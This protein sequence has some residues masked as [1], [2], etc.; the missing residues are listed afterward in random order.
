MYLGGIDFEIINDDIIIYEDDYSKLNMINHLCIRYDDNGKQYLNTFLKKY[1]Q[2]L[3][4]LKEIDCIHSGVVL[5]YIPK[6]V[7]SVRA[8]QIEPDDLWQIENLYLWNNE[9]NTIFTIENIDLSKIKFLRIWNNFIT[10]FSQL[11]NLETFHLMCRIWEREYKDINI[12]SNVLTTHYSYTGVYDLPNS[13]KKLRYYVKKETD[14][15][16][17]RNL[18]EL[19]LVFITQ[20][21]IKLSNE[22]IH[23]LRIEFYIHGIDAVDLDFPNLNSLNVAIISEVS[24]ND[25]FTNNTMKLIHNLLNPNCKKLMFINLNCDFDLDVNNIEDL[26]I[27][28]RKSINYNHKIISESIKSIEIENA[29]IE[30]DLPNLN[31]FKTI[32]NVTHCKINNMGDMRKINEFKMY[33]QTRVDIRLINIHINNLIIFNDLPHLLHNIT[34]PMNYETLELT[35]YYDSLLIHH[36]LLSLNIYY[37][38]IHKD[39]FKSNSFDKIFRPNLR[40]VTSNVDLNNILMVSDNCEVEMEE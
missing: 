24:I 19:S 31:T 9:S 37:S 26:K 4:N 11:V 8:S 21:S 33:F 40:K 22:Y 34:I 3:P 5:K 18:E 13:L 10:D 23:T 17:L 32:H 38:I 27:F 28:H 35:N 16:H 30:F 7:T 36:E 6:T 25:N 29:N 20:S 14:L 39:G 1:E 12:Q 15:S 2:L